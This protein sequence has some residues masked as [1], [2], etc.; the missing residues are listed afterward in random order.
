MKAQNAYDE[1]VNRKSEVIDKTQESKKTAR[2]SELKKIQQN[3][4]SRFVSSQ[5]AYEKWLKDKEKSDLDRSINGSR[6]NSFSGKQQ[7]QQAPFLP[8][9]SQKNTGRIRH[10]VW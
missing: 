7:Q 1:W 9:G 4:E 5:E 6:R 3:E 2:S 8:G 10:V